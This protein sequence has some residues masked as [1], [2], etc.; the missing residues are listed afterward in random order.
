MSLFGRAF[1]VVRSLDYGHIQILILGETD[2]NIQIEKEKKKK[3]RMEPIK[4]R[5]ER[6]ENRVIAVDMGEADFGGVFEGA[7][8]FPPC[9]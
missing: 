5:G 6:E 2:F 7:I 4:N 1:D 8:G 3:E 9:L